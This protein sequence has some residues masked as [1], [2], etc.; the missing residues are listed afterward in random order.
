MADLP[1]DEVLVLKLTEQEAQM[2]PQG[3]A[4]QKRRWQMLGPL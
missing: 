1:Q 3:S 2:K 4:V